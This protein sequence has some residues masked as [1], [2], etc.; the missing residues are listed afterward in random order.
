MKA[1]EILNESPQNVMYHM[2]ETDRVPSILKHGLRPVRAGLRGV[3]QKKPSIFL[4]NGLDN[5]TL[6]EIAGIVSYGGQDLDDDSRADIP[7]TILRIDLNVLFEY[8]SKRGIR[9]HWSGDD[10]VWAD[11]YVTDQP[12][13][14]EA[15]AVQQSVTDDIYESQNRKILDEKVSRGRPVV[16]VDVQP[17]YTGGQEYQNYNHR[18][19]NFLAEHRG[20]ILMYVNADDSGLTEDNIERN[21]YPWWAEIFEDL[22]YDFYE[23]GLPKM[24]F[25]DKGYGYLRGWMDSGVDERII[26]Q[27]VREMYRQK[28]YDSRDL[29]DGDPDK[30]NEFVR[31]HTGRLYHDIPVP[32][33]ITD[34]PISVGWA[35][36]NQLKRYNNCYLIGGGAEECLAEVALLMSAFN[37][38][39][40]KVNNLI[41]GS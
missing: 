3:S 28:V 24:E 20:P 40:T 21:I 39:Y 10:G 5:E 38:K 33:V 34:E 8:D 2:T 36:L 11:A 32:S 30:L 1:N 6:S 18:V 14:A 19:G 23:D 22:G 4:F 15:I 27:T 26:I 29:F 25:Y 12:I 16:C 35:A 17:G 41:Y 9:R 7:L 13:P 37:I 31:S